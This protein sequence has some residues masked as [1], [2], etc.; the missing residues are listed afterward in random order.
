MRERPA[1]R[2]VQLSP[3]AVPAATPVLRRTAKSSMRRLVAAGEL[4]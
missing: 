1:S 3:L 2:R 4:I